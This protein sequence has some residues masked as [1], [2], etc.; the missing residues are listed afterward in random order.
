[1][2]ENPAQV[3]EVEAKFPFTDSRKVNGLL[4]HQVN[5]SRNAQEKEG[6]DRAIKQP[7]PGFLGRI[8]RNNS[9]AE[10]TTTRVHVNT[11][12]GHA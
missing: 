5:Q 8:G 11:H 9:G 6:N 1:L 2:R 7:K 10:N 12:L 3:F 4:H